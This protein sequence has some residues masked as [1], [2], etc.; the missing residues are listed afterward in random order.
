MIEVYI[1]MFNCSLAYPERRMGLT[2][3]YHNFC[4][5]TS[6][7]RMMQHVITLQ[8]N[9]F[10]YSLRYHCCFTHLFTISNVYSLSSSCW[11]CP[12]HHRAQWSYPTHTLHRHFHSHV[13]CGRDF[14]A[15]T[16]QLAKLA[17]GIPLPVH[18]RGSSAGE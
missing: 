5:P 8:T 2:T 10:I 17:K 4:K 16:S 9:P 3:T 12:F 7:L 11:F 14:I 1:V 13:T 15:G 18:A 6:P